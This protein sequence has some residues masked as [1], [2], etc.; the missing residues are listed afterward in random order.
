[1]PGWR[2]WETRQAQDLVGVNPVRVQIP[3]PALLIPKMPLQKLL[4]NYLSYL[5]YEKNYSPNT[6]KSYKKDLITFLSFLKNKRVL[7][8]EELNLPLLRIYYFYLKEKKLSPASIARN[9]SSVRGFLKYLLKLQKIRKNLSEFLSNPKVPKK[10]PFVPGE[11]EI[12]TAIEQEKNED[13]LSLRNRAIFEIAYGCGL[14]VSEIANLNLKNLDLDLR[15]LKI[16]GKGGKERIVP[17]G[18]KGAEVLKKYLIKRNEYLAKLKK[19]SEYL[20]LN[21]RGEKI[22]DR[23][24]RLLVKKWGIKHG[25]PYLHPHTLRHAF[26][27]HLL[28]AGADLRSIQE[29]LGHSNL[30]TTEIYTKVNY[31]YLLKTYLKAHPRAYSKENSHKSKGS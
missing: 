7:K 1:M 28:N 2:N 23:G 4:N 27:T 11:E 15:I 5:S 9:L 17:I 10:I 16:K 12:N 14:R 6:L 31:E 3:P 18:K 24:I 20:F 29:L 25:I 26:A 8:P 13:F 30:A 22:S 21:F 19:T